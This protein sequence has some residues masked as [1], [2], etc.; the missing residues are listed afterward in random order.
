MTD[1]LDPSTSVAATALL[2]LVFGDLPA[3]IER[4]DLACADADLSVFFL[5]QGRSAVPAVALCSGC[6]AKRECRAWADARG[7]EH[8]IFG[9]TTPIQ[10]HEKKMGRRP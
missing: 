10:R 9:G 8:G 4:D 3:F 6:P 2:N 1:D 5:A 7:F